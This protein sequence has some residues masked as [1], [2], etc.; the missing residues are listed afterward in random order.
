MGIAS[1]NTILRKAMLAHAVGADSVRDGMNAGLAGGIAD[2]IRSYGSREHGVSQ[3]I[4]NPAEA[5]FFI[6]C[7]QPATATA[8][9]ECW[10]MSSSG[11]G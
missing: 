7:D 11:C 10:R 6:A 8:R 3:A 5:G 2:K 1:L 9:P 4:K